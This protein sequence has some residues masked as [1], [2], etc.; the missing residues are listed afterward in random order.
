MKIHSFNKD[1]EGNVD[2][3]VDMNNEEAEKLIH[4]A[5]YI[6]FLGGLQEHEKQDDGSYDLKL[7]DLPDDAYFTA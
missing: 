1:E 4:Y 3:H 5:I 6:T 2:F 7:K